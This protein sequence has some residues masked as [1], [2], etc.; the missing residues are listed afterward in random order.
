MTPAQRWVLALV[1]V[2]SLMVVLDL[3][4]VT[5]ALNTIR[6]D[7]GA[8][9]EDL[10][11]TVNAFTFSFAIL[12]LP[13]AALGERLGRKRLF[14]AGL[15]LF[16]VTSAACALAPNTGSLIAARAVQGVGSAMIMPHAM[17][18]PRRLMTLAEMAHVAAFMASDNASGMTGTTVNLTMGNFDD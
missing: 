10:E 16:T 15:G 11:W 14:I 6:L 3:L 5:T 12:L 4:V 9:I 17:T 8:S 2:A 7:L 18:H 1:S 13:A